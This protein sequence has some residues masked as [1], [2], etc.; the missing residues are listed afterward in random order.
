M[1]GAIRRNTAGNR[2]LVGNVNR[3]LDTALTFM[4]S[5][6]RSSWS[7]GVIRTASNIWLSS[8]FS[9]TSVSTKAPP[10]NLSSHSSFWAEQRSHV[11]T[12]KNILS[13]KRFKKNGTSP[14]SRRAPSVPAWCS[15][16][17]APS[18]GA[19]DSG[20]C[21]HTAGEQVTTWKSDVL[22]ATDGLKY[23]DFILQIASISIIIIISSVLL[24]INLYFYSDDVSGPLPDIS[25]WSVG[26]ATSDFFSSPPS[27]VL[28]VVSAARKR[29]RAVGTLQ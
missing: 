20:P 16:T 7:D 9:M 26:Y 15:W 13:E 27:I 11:R 24:K 17:P 21:R 22:N 28:R 19:T 10:T 23:I 4:T 2:K 18:G 1:G 25:G 3:K 6:C 8:C 5:T 14:A 12:Q 29:G